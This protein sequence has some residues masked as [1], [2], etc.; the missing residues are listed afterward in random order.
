[1]FDITHGTN[2]EGRP[3]GISSSCD[4]NMNVFTPFRVFM[5]SECPWVLMWIFK[6]AIPYLLGLEA[7]YH[8]QLVLSD[9]DPKIYKSFDEVEDEIYPNAMHGPGR[10]HLVKKSLDRLKVELQGF[11]RAIIRNQVITMKHWYIVG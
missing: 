4:S 10:F 8:I 9:D 11:S 7:L 2:S 6:T 3:L 5:P 1:M